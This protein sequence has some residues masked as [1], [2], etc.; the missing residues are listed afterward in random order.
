MMFIILT[1][2]SLQ[3]TLFFLLIS[4]RGQFLP[5]KTLTNSVDVTLVSDSTKYDVK[6]T[7]VFLLFFIVMLDIFR[8]LVSLFLVYRKN[9]LFLMRRLS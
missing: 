9:S 8:Q 1:G 6:V 3:L 2:H 4:Y 7:V 5:S